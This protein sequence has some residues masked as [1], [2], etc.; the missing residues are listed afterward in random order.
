MCYVIWMASKVVDPQMPTSVIKRAVD[1]LPAL[2]IDEAR[3]LR[4]A[5]RSAAD[6]VL[7]QIYKRL[8]DIALN[9]DNEKLAAMVGLELMK[10]SLKGKSN[11]EI[12]PDQP[13][14][15]GEVVGRDPIAELEAQT[16]STGDG[17]KE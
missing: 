9:S 12:D 7:P 11:E 6:V 17:T 2:P 8:V 1:E 15:D 3:R 13:T 5:V 14:V 16:E 10:V 4:R